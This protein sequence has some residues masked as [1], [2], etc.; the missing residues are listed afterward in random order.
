[1]STEECGQ[2]NQRAH[3]SA[4]QSVTHQVIPSASQSSASE[5]VSQ[6]SHEISL[7]FYQQQLLCRICMFLST[8]CPAL[9]HRNTYSARSYLCW[10]TLRITYLHISVDL[11][12][13]YLNDRIHSVLAIT[14][15]RP[16]KGV[17]HFHTGE[18]AP[19]HGERGQM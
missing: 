15:N 12:C 11:F 2:I 13:L 19:P 9:T 7:A 5:A 17:W 14:V 16:G 3:Q 10:M 4:S 6:S 18:K 8:C 1:M